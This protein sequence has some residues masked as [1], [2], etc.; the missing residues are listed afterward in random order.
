MQQKGV[1]GN[2]NVSFFEANNQAGNGRVTFCYSMTSWTLW[3]LV[4]HAWVNWVWVRS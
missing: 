4:S 2:A 1:E 3:T